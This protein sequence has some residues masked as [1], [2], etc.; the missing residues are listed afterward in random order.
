M[1]GN[2]SNIILA[3]DVMIKN[4]NYYAWLAMGK[5]LCTQM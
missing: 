2:S 5:K 4:V 3:P 1:T